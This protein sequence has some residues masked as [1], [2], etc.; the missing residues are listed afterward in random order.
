MVNERDRSELLEK[1]T[2]NFFKLDLLEEKKMIPKNSSKI[3]EYLD[4][5]KYEGE[6]DEK[7]AKQGYG[8]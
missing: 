7:G 4:G 1:F 5:D 3:I 8:I 6:V 2:M